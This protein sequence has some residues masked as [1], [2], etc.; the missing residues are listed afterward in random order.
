MTYF[1]EMT[2]GHNVELTVEAMKA[3]APSIFA[4]QAHNEVSDRYGFVPTIQVVEG[5]RAEGWLPV[6]ATQK[7]VR[8]ADKQDFTK[9]LIRFRRLEDDIKIGDSAVELLLT[10]SHDR[11]AAFVL[12]AGIFRMACANGIVVADSTF[13]K[14]SVRHNQNAL[15]DVIEGSYQVLEEVPLITNEVESMQA[16]ELTRKEQEIFANAA[17]GYIM[18]ELNEEESKIVTSKDSLITQALRPRRSADTG[19]DVWSTYNVLQEK[20]IRGGLSMHKVNAKGRYRR[21]TTRAVKSIDKDVKL[22]KALWEMAVQMKE[23]KA[24]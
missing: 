5:L 7:N 21:N 10:N 16:V 14:V 8:K 24:A 19:S 13:N 23:L 20:A 6:D 18:P 4:E 11:S 9:H 15:D 2:Q 12:H 1:R 22:N 17:L 3:N